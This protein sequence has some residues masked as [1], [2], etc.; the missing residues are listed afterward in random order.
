[1]S[2]TLAISTRH[3]IL[4][5]LTLDDIPEVQRLVSDK[6]VALMTSD[7]EIPQLG[8]EEQWFTVRQE[9]FENR[10]VVDLLDT[11]SVLVEETTS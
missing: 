9:R 7:S 4:R 3:L 11:T 8:F 1:M 10:E 5:L 2:T 6:D